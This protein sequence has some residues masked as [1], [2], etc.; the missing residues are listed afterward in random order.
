MPLVEI[1]G[2]SFHYQR[3]GQGSA[4]VFVHGGFANL[5]LQ[6]KLPAA[7][8]W[9]WSWEWDFANDFD[10][11]WYDR[12]GCYHSSRPVTNDYSLEAQV[13]DLEGLLDHLNIASAHLIGSSAGGPIAVVFAATKPDR[14]KSLILTGTACD[15]FP[16]DDKPTKIIQEQIAILEAAGPETAF[17][18]RPEGIHTS[19]D[20]L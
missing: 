5:A 18:H 4:V 7:G 19:V 1:K 12:R 2:C 20:V 14:V 16:P 11:V 3:A 9:E 8:E 10:F 15:V 13:A 17:A 6:L